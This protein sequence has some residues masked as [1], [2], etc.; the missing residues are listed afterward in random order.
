MSYRIV[1]TGEA[2]Q[3]LAGIQDRREQGVLLTRL[4]LT[5]PGLPAILNSEAID[6]WLATNVAATQ[7]KPAAA[8]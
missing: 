1:L 7:T 3:L 8:G 6:R 2:K 4:A 5:H